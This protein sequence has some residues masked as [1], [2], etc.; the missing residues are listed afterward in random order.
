[1]ERNK[2][3]Q[4]LM[5][6]PEE[7]EAYAEPSIMDDWIKQNDPEQWDK[8]Q[9]ARNTQD[10]INLGMSTA[11]SMKLPRK[12]LMGRFAPIRKDIKDTKLQLPKDIYEKATSHL[13][14]ETPNLG[15][16][17]TAELPKENI[18]KVTSTE[19]PESAIGKVTNVA[20]EEA[21]TLMERLNKMENT[22]NTDERFKRLNELLKQK[23]A[24][25]G[26]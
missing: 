3:L 18:G 6:R 5:M 12:G 20:D 17:T 26:E 24:Q 23:K 9:S 11:G 25:K 1:M 15:K 13:Q 7:M 16:V 21:L 8:I 2:I 22:L 19:L 4:T 10:A 14:K